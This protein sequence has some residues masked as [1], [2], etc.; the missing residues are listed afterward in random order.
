MSFLKETMYSLI[1]KPS[2]LVITSDP[3]EMCGGV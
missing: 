3:Q 1:Q 2:L